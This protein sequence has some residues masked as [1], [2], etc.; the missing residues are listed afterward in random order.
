MQPTSESLS[1][2]WLLIEG[3]RELEL[4]VK[5]QLIPHMGSLFVRQAAS[6]ET[7]KRACGLVIAPI[8]SSLENC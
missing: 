7:R 4:S 6:G 2:Y 8:S 5:G 1:L 3:G